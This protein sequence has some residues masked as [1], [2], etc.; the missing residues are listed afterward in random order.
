MYKYVSRFGILLLL[1][2]LSSSCNY[3]IN[4]N[5]RKNHK[6]KTISHGFSDYWL[7]SYDSCIFLTPNDSL[8]ASAK[9]ISDITIFHPS[10]AFDYYKEY[11]FTY[12]MEERLKDEAK[13]FK[14]NLIRIVGDGETTTL[15]ARI[16]L[17]AQLYQIPE[18]QFILLE[19]KLNYFPL[20]HPTSSLIHLYSHITQP[21]E[22]LYQDTT[23]YVCTGG[24]ARHLPACRLDVEVRGQGFL[25]MNLINPMNSTREKINHLHIDPGN[26]Y[27]VI[28]ARSVRQAPHLVRVTRYEFETIVK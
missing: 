20:Y 21:L 15:T 7:S 6:I 22:I 25:Q 3:Q 10:S 8:P 19:N 17:K 24:N 2:Y 16:Y 12:A 11:S 28:V 1:L 26:V 13:Y 14:C 9:K 18:E 5:G 27:F 4:I 23:L